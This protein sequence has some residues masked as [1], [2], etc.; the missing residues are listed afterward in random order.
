MVRFPFSILQYSHGRHHQHISALG[1]EQIRTLPHPSQRRFFCHAVYRLPLEQIHAPVKKKLA[2]VIIRPA[3]QHH[4]PG[5][6]SPPHFRIPRV[7][8]VRRLPVCERRD[9]HSFSF[10]IIKR[11]SVL[12][13]D[14]QLGRFITVIRIFMYIL[15]IY[16]IIVDSG[17]VEIQLSFIFHSAS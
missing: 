8:P 17:I 16:N 13:T 14:H 1:P 3:A 10:K 15:W 6:L 4:I 11:K 12:R 7:C 9:D 5:I 2:S